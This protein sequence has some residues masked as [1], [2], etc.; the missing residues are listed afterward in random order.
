[1]AFISV[2][3]QT[4]DNTLQKIAGVN[5]TEKEKTTSALSFVLSP[6]N[7][8]YQITSSATDLLLLSNDG[9]EDINL[10]IGSS[11]AF[12]LKAGECLSSLYGINSSLS[13]E[14]SGDVEIPLRVIY[15]TPVH[16]SV[17]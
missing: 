8:P 3:I 5:G 12:A 13:V 6:G 4:N 15:T 16:T 2:N 11:P 17:N 9:S 7:S 14:I 10:Y 1:M